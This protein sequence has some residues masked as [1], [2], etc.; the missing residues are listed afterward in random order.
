MRNGRLRSLSLGLGVITILSVA[1]DLVNFMHVPYRGG[2]PA[3]IDLRGLS[4]LDRK[5]S[6]RRGPT[7][8]SALGKLR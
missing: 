6:R 1:S 5:R 3:M 4:A 7:Q 2:G 8:R